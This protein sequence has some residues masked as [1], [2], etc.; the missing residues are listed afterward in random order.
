MEKELGGTGSIATLN[1][2]DTG[3]EMFSS[4]SESLCMRRQDVLL[5]LP[6]KTLVVGTQFQ[7]ERHQPKPTKKVKRHSEE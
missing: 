1:G 7:T 5:A 4:C 6:H 2:Q 3:T